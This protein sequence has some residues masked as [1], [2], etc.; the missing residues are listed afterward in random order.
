M[1]ENVKTSVVSS[2]NKVNQSHLFL[3][4]FNISTI[5]LYRKHWVIVNNTMHISGKGPSFNTIDDY[6]LK[7]ECIIQVN[8]FICLHGV[9]IKQ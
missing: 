3:K 1:H 6:C 5:T 9:W 4:K 7:N 2:M 8:D